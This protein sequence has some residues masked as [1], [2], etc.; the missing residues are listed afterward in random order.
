MDNSE[1]LK[2]VIEDIILPEYDVIGSV[3]I[4][5]FGG[6]GDIYFYDIYFLLKSGVN[7]IPH[8]LMKEITFETT[9]LANMIGMEKGNDFSVGFITPEDFE[10]KLAR[11][12]VKL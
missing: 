6:L 2:K 11:K 10:K 4:K 5:T 12:R 9:S 3:Y 1:V 8:S 7:D